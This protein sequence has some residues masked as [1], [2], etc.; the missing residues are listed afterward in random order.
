MGLPPIPQRKNLQT[1]FR[2]GGEGWYPPIFCPENLY[3]VFSTYF[4]PFWSISRPFWPICNLDW[5]TNTN[6]WCKKSKVYFGHQNP[7]YFFRS[8]RASCTTSG[9]LVRTYGAMKIWTPIYRHICLMNHQETPQTN[10]LATWDPLDVSLNPLGPPGPP[11]R[12]P[13][14]PKEISWPHWPL[15]ITSTALL[16]IWG[17]I[18]FNFPVDPM[19]YLHP[20]PWD[21]ET[22]R[23]WDLEILRPWDLETLKPWD[24]K[25]LRP[26]HL[27]TLRPWD[28]ETLRPWDL[29]TL[30]PWDLGTLR[31]WDL[32]PLGRDGQR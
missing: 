1:N 13:G 8:A 7:G 32:E 3:S 20:P 28:L 25:T 19:G 24:L 5:Y 12:P 27:D 23:P 26:W 16:I 14:T 4:S 17:P 2:K 11:H 31:P 15:K 10:P 29:E 21:L 18:K 22:L 9:G 6:F 30:R